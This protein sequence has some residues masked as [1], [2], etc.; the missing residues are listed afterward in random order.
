MITNIEEFKQQLDIV[1]IIGDYIELK[2]AGAN[3]KA[4]CPFHDEK[5]GS[6]VISPAKQIAHCFGCGKTQ[7]SIQ[8]VMDFKHL[9]FFEAVEEIANNINFT[10]TYDKTQGTKK[11]YT[12]VL[13]KTLEFY[14]S[15]KSQAYQYLKD[16][17]VRDESM[18][19]FE[20]GFAPS[21]KEQI[22]FL[23]SEMFPQVDT[24][25][26][27]ITAI[28]DGKLY[29][30]LTKRIVFPIRN[31]ANKLI[32]FGGRVLDGDDRAKYINSPQTP[33]FDKSRNFYG[34]NLAK[35]HIHKKGTITIT[36]GYLDVVMF[37]QVGIKTAVATMGTALTEQHARLILKS[38]LRV[39]LCFD[40]DRAGA[41]AGFK[42]S[43]LLA[44]LGV[45]GG[46]VLF[47]EGKDPADMIKENK[48][49]ELM[50]IMKKPLNIIKYSINY[51]ASKHNL[52]LPTQK[53]NAIAEVNAFLATLT[54]V[55]Q[56]EYKKYVAYKLQIAQEHIQVST[57]EQNAPTYQPT[58]ISIAELSII[59]TARESENYLNL[60]LDY[61]SIDMF[62][63]HAREFDMVLRNDNA[64]D[65]LLL[66]D[67]IQVY[68]ESELIKQLNIFLAIYY[69]KE[70][71]LVM[72]NESILVDE[73]LK[74]VKELQGKILNL[75]TGVM[76]A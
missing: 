72:S 17:G 60:V 67:D 58:T 45:D 13:E 14:K 42:A 63:S 11:D 71:S 23:N 69:A 31:Q 21:S 32:G 64:V 37:H 55:L 66:R 4:N 27:G 5:S 10:L 50:S 35:E 41:N 51:I 68:N 20:I 7:D 74:K 56:D 12:P 36:E 2:K 57:H 47:P 53:Q 65:G 38:K 28:G 16:R 19:A 44:S 29:A 75:K 52:E 26:V 54:P 22:D 73:K 48:I 62:E 25:E 3:F 6:F 1:D 49:D 33:L 61:I 9:E 59:K 40:G 24:N 39:L 70:I 30:R 18:I 8:F 15:N 46:V 76:S 34:Y 43:V